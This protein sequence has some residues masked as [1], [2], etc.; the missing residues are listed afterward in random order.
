VPSAIHRYFQ[1]WTEQGV[2]KAK[3]QRGFQQYDELCG[4]IDWKW[5]CIDGSMNKAS[6]AQ[7]SVGPDPTDRGK[8]KRQV[9]VDGRGVPLSVML[10]G[11]HVNDVW[12][13]VV[14]CPAWEGIP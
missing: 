8:M 2:F 14:E 13:M 12:M 1:L 3:W 7:E 4:G 10:T 6:M 11:A 9:L 5:Q